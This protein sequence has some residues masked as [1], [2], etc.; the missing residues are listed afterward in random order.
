MTWRI[1]AMLALCFVQFVLSLVAYVIGGMN[2]DTFL[3]VLRPIQKQW[4]SAC[5][6]FRR[7]ERPGERNA[8]GCPFGTHRPLCRVDGRKGSH[9]ASTMLHTNTHAHSYPPR[10]HFIRVQNKHWN[11]YR[12]IIIY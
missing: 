9:I 7:T 1:L 3:K 10:K 8:M 6:S 4:V 12:F 5:T 2:N 11:L